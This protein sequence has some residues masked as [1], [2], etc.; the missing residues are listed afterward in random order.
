MK[1][2]ISV[3]EAAPVSMMEALWWTRGDYNV[4]ELN[5]LSMTDISV[6]QHKERKFTY[7]Y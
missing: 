7:Q 3:T 5:K 4:I 1:T 2:D 6:E